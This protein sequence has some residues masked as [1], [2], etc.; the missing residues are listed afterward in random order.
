[1]ASS[2]SSF[3]TTDTDHS[4]IT[5]TVC[6]LKVTWYNAC[7]H[8]NFENDCWFAKHCRISN[9][10]TKGFLELLEA[11]LYPTVLEISMFNIKLPDMSIV[12]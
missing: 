10:K 6:M 4:Y 7:H 5:E 9:V 8:H 2:A 11:L 3:V 12:R 1:M